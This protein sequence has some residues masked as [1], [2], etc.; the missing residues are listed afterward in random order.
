VTLR[1]VRRRLRFGELP[2]AR[3]TTALGL[4]MQLAAVIHNQLRTLSPRSSAMPK[5][6]GQTLDLTNAVFASPVARKNSHSSNRKSKSHTNSVSASGNVLEYYSPTAQA[7]QDL[8]VN[9]S[10]GHPLSRPG[11]DFLRNA[12]HEVYEVKS[13]DARLPSLVITPFEMLRFI[14]SRLSFGPDG[15]LYSEQRQPILEIH[16]G[17]AN[18]VSDCDD[19]V[20]RWQERSFNDFDARFMFHQ[21]VVNFNLCRS[22][23]QEYLFLKMQQTVDANVSDLTIS[24]T[25][26]YFSKHALIGEQMSLLSIGNSDSG[27]TI[28]LEFVY[29]NTAPRL[30]FDDAHSCFVPLSLAAFSEIEDAVT[31]P[32]P[33]PS[34]SDM[35]Q[36]SECDVITADKD[37][38]SSSVSSDDIHPSSL[39]ESSLSSHTTLRAPPSPSAIPRMKRD[40]GCAVS[41][42]KGIYAFSLSGDYN[43]MRYRRARNLLHVQQPEQVS[44]GLPLLV[45]AV[46]VKRY[47]IPEE[48]VVPLSQHFAS[49][50]VSEAAAN[51]LSGREPASFLQSFIRS[52]CNGKA[53]QAMAVVA[54]LI[55][56]V[57]VY[58][59]PAL[60]IRHIINPLA[61]LYVHYCCQLM[62][63]VSQQ[64][65]DGSDDLRALLRV[66][67]YI[68]Q[69]CLGRGTASAPTTEETPLNTMEEVCSSSG[70]A[71]LWKHHPTQHS[72]SFVRHRLFLFACCIQKQL[73]YSMKSLTPVVN[74]GIMGVSLIFVENTQVTNECVMP[75][76]VEDH[77]PERAVAPSSYLSAV[78]SSQ[79]APQVEANA[80]VSNGPTVKSWSQMVKGTA[81]PVCFTAPSSV[82][83]VAAPQPAAAPAAASFS[84]VKALACARM[85]ASALEEQ[86][87]RACSCIWMQ[88]FNAELRE[89][90]FSLFF[91]GQIMQHINIKFRAEFERELLSRRSQNTDADPAIEYCGERDSGTLRFPARFEPK[92]FDSK[93]AKEVSSPAPH[94]VRAATQSPARGWFDSLRQSV[95]DL[96]P[97]I[98]RGVSPP[99]R[100]SSDSSRD[101]QVDDGVFSFTLGSSRRVPVS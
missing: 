67:Q 34:C 10:A 7:H 91:E 95:V 62:A 33:S 59:K 30:Y 92:A 52:H 94:A 6:R 50:F 46:L 97:P 9:P 17:V 26:A 79:S 101:L 5:K 75:S 100:C 32:S 58:A 25:F 89:V 71:Y 57:S 84:S 11:L 31:P 72:D 77:V 40:G 87:S 1:A 20:M 47:T 51:V 65:A 2:K 88:L 4:K 39:G 12:L 70:P 15:P 78:S 27:K 74:S 22:I 14:L 96:L 54:S 82:P 19:G 73:Q 8:F 48:D 37:L 66:A 45:H 21:G 83:T 63:Q 60:C 93:V 3:N 85:E 86:F 99:K 36:L 55:V 90:A 76:D 56:H 41:V 61:S 23:V 43:L 49:S 38:C 81:V 80:S 98:L 44:N 29:I 69:P 68:C 13:K 28:D 35:L 64:G 16:G 42:P 24:S 18:H 53:V